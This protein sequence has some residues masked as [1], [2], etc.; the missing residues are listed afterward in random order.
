ME[1]AVP[2]HAKPPLPDD[3]E[4]ELSICRVMHGTS[5]RGLCPQLISGVH[6]A[7]GTYPGDGLLRVASGAAL[8]LLLD[9]C[10]LGLRLGRLLQPFCLALPVRHLI[11]HHHTSLTRMHPRVC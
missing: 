3:L 2:C 8:V 9:N 10:R 6:A 1:P 7:I 11:S 4:T 5:F